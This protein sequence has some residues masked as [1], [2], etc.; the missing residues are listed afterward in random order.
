MAKVK[1]ENDCTVGACLFTN[2]TFLDLAPHSS[3]KP[4]MSQTQLNLSPPEQT[5]CGY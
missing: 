2:F 5:L 3:P 4:A 1:G